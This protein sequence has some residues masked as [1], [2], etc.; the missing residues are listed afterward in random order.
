MNKTT[1][2]IVV[3]PTKFN[4]KEFAGFIT[5]EDA[6]TMRK[7]IGLSNEQHHGTSFHRNK[8]NGMLYIT[9]VLKEEMSRTEIDRQNFKK[10]FWIHKESKAGNIDTIRGTVVFPRLDNPSNSVCNSSCQDVPIGNN[11]DIKIIRFG[12]TNY[13]LYENEISE[14]IKLYGKQESTIMEESVAYNNDEQSQEKLQDHALNPENSSTSRILA[15][16]TGNYLVKIRLARS[17]PSIVP[18]FGLKIRVSYDGMKKMCERCYGY[19]RRNATSTECKK[20]DFE[21]YKQR[22]QEDNPWIPHEMTNFFVSEDIDYTFD[23]G[24]VFEELEDDE[25]LEDQDNTNSGLNNGQ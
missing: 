5:L 18:M 24:Y 4:K 22:F 3:S 8:T 23:Y 25:N 21:N 10:E 17:I 15:K 7:A 19:H 13:E 6:D 14:W 1:D 12:N 9:F 16:G 2:R 11:S 20:S